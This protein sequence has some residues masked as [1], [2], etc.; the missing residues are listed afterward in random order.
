MRATKGFLILA[1]AAAVWV[2]TGAVVASPAAQANGTYVALGDSV[3]EPT[4]SYVSIFFQFLRTS[5][6]GDLDT[7]HNRAMSGA[8]SS[9]LRRG[10][11]ATAI[12]D[13]DGPSDTKV[14]T[15]DIGGNDR[16]QCGGPPPTW[17]LS[18]CPFAANFDATLADLQAALRRDPG[19]EALIAM[20]YYN[21]A[22]GT[23]SR[24]ERLYDRGLLG[25]D[26]RISCAPSGDPRLGLND[27]IVY[28]SKARGALVADVYPAFKLGGQALI[29]D[30]LHPN[31]PGQ[32]V[33]AGEFRKALTASPPDVNP[34]A[35]FQPPGLRLGGRRT[36]KA[37]K[38]IEVIVRATT[39]DL[40]I[41]ATGK[42]RVR[43]WKTAYKLKGVKSC[44]VARGDRAT[45]RLNVSKKAVRAIRRALRRH[46]KVSAK[47]RI[48]ARDAA[49]NT[50]LKRRTIKL[51]G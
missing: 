12:A 21:A 10:Q 48:K 14:V 45:L 6:G 42:V 49:G 36:Q 19:S 41:T 43:G 3:A 17:H 24:Q 13:I 11:L 26:L 18:F 46:K 51:R 39:K 47:L 20:T 37:R 4:D 32:A 28:I 25:T 27:R 23:G 9:S 35:E 31:G 34:P 50:T 40:R 15:I 33:I 7:L 38:T 5:E 8:D 2:A 44:F 1:C 29:A 22:T 30:G 16:F